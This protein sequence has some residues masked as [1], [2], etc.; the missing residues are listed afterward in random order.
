M[1]RK[2]I[3]LAAC[4]CVALFSLAVSVFLFPRVHPLGAFHP[5]LSRAEV[6]EHASTIMKDVGA[7]VTG[8]ESSLRLSADDDLMREMYTRDGVAAANESMR[9]SAPALLWIVSW[10]PPEG[11]TGSVSGPPRRR[12]SG[13]GS[14]MLQWGP[15]VQLDMRGHLLG[16][17]V[18]IADSASVTPLDS[19]AARALAEK[20]LSSRC[21][22]AGVQFTRE[23]RIELPNRVDREIAFAATDTTTSAEVEASVRIVGNRVGEFSIK[24]TGAPLE[25]TREASPVRYVLLVFL[26]L[27]IGVVV[28]IAAIRR[29]RAYEIGFRYAYVLGAVAALLE[30]I[31]NAASMQSFNG[32]SSVLNITLVPLLVGGAFTLLWIIG[33]SISRETFR[34]KF[35]SLDLVT[36]G[37]PF[38]SRVGEDVIKGIAGGIAAI[39]FS[40]VVIW[41]GEHIFSVWFSGQKQDGLSI[42]SSGNPLLFG[43]ADKLLSALFVLAFVLMSFLGILRKRVSSPVLLTLA[44]VL[45]VGLPN[46]IEL[47]PEWI[48]IL[49]R[50]VSA[51]L[52]VWVLLRSSLLSGLTALLIWH[53]SDSVLAFLVADHPAFVPAGTGFLLIGG[54]FFVIGCVSLLTKDR[55]VEFSSLVPD[56]AKHIT[57]R[58]R[59]QQELEVARKVQMSFLPKEDPKVPGLDIASRC[60]PALEVGGDYYDFVPLGEDTLGIAVGDV[61]G[62]GLQ[63]SFY[64]TLAKGFLRA[65]AR[66]MHSPALVLKGANEL[67][68]ENVEKGTFISMVYGIADLRARTFTFARAGHSLVI[69]KR[70]AAS[71]PELLR[72]SGMAL[73]LEQS[74]QFAESLEEVRMA[75]Q[76]GDLIIIYTDGFTEAMDSKREEFGEE[77]LLLAVR[78]YAQGNARQILDG[79]FGEVKSF[80]RK[81]EQHDD[82]TMVVTKWT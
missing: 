81:H 73:G 29:I 48:G 41:L 60:V 34:E 15:E 76:S 68:S 23:R 30:A 64:M 2:L 74:G 59:L 19:A 5:L 27:G 8:Y 63:A 20:L 42:L 69:V 58:E 24:R 55:A 50:M 70:A 54:A 39:A 52:L 78:R 72:S 12:S 79:V 62:K 51:L 21:A 61:S 49:I 37:H 56:F 43:I 10:R 46:S 36:N 33:E 53:L 38:H 16:V 7:S 45:V 17:S 1:K 65:V 44:G 47:R 57:E 82:M 26:F 66:G 13:G 77:R 35:L 22:F 28:V 71:D 40:L 67:F 31:T 25:E 75:M 4:L 6:L 9:G 11:M 14:E 18:P 3:L 32:W 80:V